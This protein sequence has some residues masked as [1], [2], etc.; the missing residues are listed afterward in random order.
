MAAAAI[1]FTIYGTQTV[2]NGVSSVKLPLP[3]DAH[4][5][6]DAADV[7]LAQFRVSEVVKIELV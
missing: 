3:A 5:I 2:E 7:E 1:V 4:S 6:R